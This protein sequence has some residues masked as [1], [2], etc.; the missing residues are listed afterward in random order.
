MIPDISEAQWLRTP[1][2][3][4]PRAFGT[5]WQG[6]DWE[7]WEGIRPWSRVG[8][9][10]RDVERLS[11]LAT[12]WGIKKNAAKDKHKVVWGLGCPLHP[13]HHVCEISKMQ[14]WMN[15]MFYYCTV[16]YWRGR[17]PE[18]EMFDF[19]PGPFL[20]PRIFRRGHVQPYPPNRWWIGKEWPCYKRSRTPLRRCQLRRIT[21]SPEIAGDA[22]GICF[23]LAPAAA[24]KLLVRHILG[25][26]LQS[27]RAL[28]VRLLEAGLWGMAFV[29]LWN[30]IAKTIFQYLHIFALMSDY[31]RTRVENPNQKVT[32]Q[33]DGPEEALLH[34]MSPWWFAYPYP[35][36]VK[37]APGPHEFFLGFHMEGIIKS[38]G[39]DY[40]WLQLRIP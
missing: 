5:D 13:W 29:L 10:W 39:W 8:E 22:D 30:N 36:S 16:F 4:P 11:V 33:L 6:A 9:E 25:V 3:A 14:V 27:T 24:G 21:N 1:P 7:F 40:L 35:L 34:A 28:L 17:C 31:G 18:F 23:R 37:Y 26:L 12:T 38:G 19:P 2:R 20:C 32:T 15:I